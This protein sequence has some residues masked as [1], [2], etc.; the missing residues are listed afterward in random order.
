M[1]VGHQAKSMW[2]ARRVLTATAR[3]LTLMCGW[4]ALPGQSGQPDVQVE[5]SSGALQGTSLVHGGAVFKGVP[6]ATAPTG[7][8]RW[9]SPA[10]VAAWKG[11]RPAIEYGSACLQ[12]D[13]GWNSSL[14]ASASEDCLYLNVWTPH[15]KRSAHLPVMVWIHGGA[16]VGGAGTDAIFGG[17][18][19]IKKGVVLVTLNYRL[20]I[21]GFM[22]H[23]ALSSESVYHSSGNYALEDQLAALRWVRDNIVGFGGDPDNIT[24]FGQSAG[25]M[26]VTTLLASPLSR[27]QIRQAIV[28][29]GSILGGP[30]MM[31]LK[32]AE[33]I[34][35]DFAGTD[36]VRAIR[37]LSS[38]EVMRRFGVYMSTHRGARLGPIIDH[39]IVNDDPADVYR[40]HEEHAVPLMIGNNAREGFGSMADEALSGALTGFYGADADRVLPLY[41]VG[42]GN[43]LPNDPVLGSA[44]AQWLTDSSF[45]CGAVITAARHAAGGSPVYEYQFEQSIPGREADGAAHTY[46]LP[47]V[48]G[49]LLSEGPLAG[50]FG[51]ADRALSNAMT[52]YWTNFAKHGNPNGRELP[53][54]PKFNNPVG[55]Y[56]RMSSSLAGGAVA[57]VGLRGAQCDLYESQINKPRT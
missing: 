20:G 5:V 16:F 30:P 39:Y 10:P 7:P 19:L 50:R 40:R 49:N 57:A 24:L 22:A 35:V 52:A 36:D 8:L 11:V 9:H 13:Q 47:Y 41:G 29:S 17:E 18:Q 28:E 33:A 31:Q 44:A 37:E 45:R 6:Y 1:V 21:F 55:S 12:P 34:G 54:W 4:C 51:A 43:P 2:Q 3:A 38:A 53:P 25:G 26:S 46:E 32:D 48:F 14:I 23:P 56:L 15:P 42:T 27:G